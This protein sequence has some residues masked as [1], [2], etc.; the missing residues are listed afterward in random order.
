MV[1][2][3]ADY[4]F[5]RPAPSLLAQHYSAVMRYVL[6]SSGKRITRAEFDDLRAEGLGVGI[7]A[8]GGTSNVLD[9][10]GQGGVD[11]VLAHTQATAAGFPADRP[12]YFAADTDVPDSEWP[13]VAA[14]LDA[15]RVLSG[16]PVQGIYG[17]AG[18]VQAMLD[19]G[20]AEFGWVTNASSWN[21]GHAAPGAHL[22][23]H[24]G[25]TVAGCD[26]NTVLQA[27][28][29]QFPPPEAPPA[30]TPDPPPPPEEEDMPGPCQEI[31]QAIEAINAVVDQ[32]T[33]AQARLGDDG[34]AFWA[35]EMVTDP[36][37]PGAVL[38]RLAAEIK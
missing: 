17:G 25:G 19:G 3:V 2:L 10:A 26:D 9:G 15:A 36:A 24:V 33:Q 6:G 7:V 12:I 29:G 37:G 27:D 38:I 28:F 30:P 35:N 16:R 18:L 20:H 14:Y 31:A 32:S 5:A 13:T 23:Q 11:G 34:L 21:H 4:S 8:E 22:Q 1:V